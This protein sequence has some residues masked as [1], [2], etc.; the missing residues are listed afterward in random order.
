MS[1]DSVDQDREDAVDVA[2]AEYLRLVDTGQ[3]FDLDEFIDGYS[4]IS[5]E[6]RELIETASTV[7]SMAVGDEHAT[8]A[9]TQQSAEDSQTLPLYAS[10]QQADTWSDNLVQLV[11]EYELIE[12]LG[13]GGMGVVYRARQ[14]RMNRHVALKMIINGEYTCEQNVRRFYKEAEAAGKLAHRNI[15][16]AYAVGEHE[17]RHFFAMELIEG[18]TLRDILKTLDDRLPAETIATHMRA[19]ADAV[20]FAHDRG[21]LHRD[22]K[23]GNIIVDRRNIP[24]I[25]DFGLAKHLTFDEDASFESSS[26]SIIGTPSYMSPE[27]AGSQ[28]DQVGP[29]SDVYSLGA[30]LYELLT[31]QPPFKDSSPVGTLLLVLNQDVTPPTDINPECD[32]DLEAICLKCLEKKP[33]DR[34]ASCAELRADF[35]R[36]SRGQ[37]VKARRLTRMQRSWFWLRG[38]PL[39]AFL[40]GRDHA[41]ATTA[42]HRSQWATAIAIGL[43]IS[44]FLARSQIREYAHLRTVDLGVAEINGHYDEIGHL[45]GGTF[46]RQPRIVNTVGSKACLQQLLGFQLDLGLMQ[47]NTIAFEDIRII[48]PLYREAVLLLVRK[49]SGIEVVEDLS[50]RAIALGQPTSGI[51]ATSDQIL[52]KLGIETLAEYRDHPWTSLSN[53]DSI[54]GA[55][56]TVSPRAKQ[57]RRLLASGEFR[58]LPLETD[59][60]PDQFRP[61]HF[62]PHELPDGA[63]L[64]DEGLPA[65]T[66]EAVLA[67]RKT[68]PNSFVR[69]TL[70]RIYSA[71][72]TDLTLEIMNFDDAAAWSGDKLMHP[73]ASK[74]FTQRSFG[75]ATD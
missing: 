27:Q 40:T 46:P 4:D 38:V 60:L 63:G 73:A 66:V 32:P 72:D 31:G 55:I 11:G 5:D 64:G 50:G 29:A 3:P 54:E 30:I 47:D 48:A 39:V 65:A 53:D 16:R 26:G 42:Q 2:F 58:I 49:S 37:P 74:F 61:Y 71:K 10:D 59:D 1:G 20:Q 57:L 14:K 23:P 17:G 33:A 19:L 28:R 7:T 51:R 25:A 41:S 69:R 8:Q 22:L 36:F 43:V 75:D 24:K 6:L 15:V 18:R 56:V 70:K 21:I 62:R 13:R 52:G 68:A 12:E 34:Y 9:A 35:D 67:V 45:I 44:L